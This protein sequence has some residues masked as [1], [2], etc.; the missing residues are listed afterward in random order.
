MAPLSKRK[1]SIGKMI[2]ERQQS[3]VQC[4]SVQLHIIDQAVLPRV[5]AA[6]AE[7]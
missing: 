7:F 5:A 4:W 2:E 1:W 6:V 3:E